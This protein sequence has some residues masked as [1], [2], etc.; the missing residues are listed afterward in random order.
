MTSVEVQ[1]DIRNA[2][3]ASETT[4]W[5]L[6]RLPPF[7]AVAMRLIQMYANPDIDI[8]EVGRTIAMEPVFAARVLRLANSPLFAARSEVKSLSHA[9]VLLGLNRVKAITITRAMA[10]Y[11]TPVLRVEALRACW[12]NN[13]AAAIVSE[14]LARACKMDPDFAYVAGLI[15][16]IG[17]LALVV[18]YPQAYANLL[19]VTEENSFNLLTVEHDL[20]ELDHCQAGTWLLE[21][22]S[23]PAELRE[24]VAWHHEALG[25][26]PFRMVNLVHVADLM[27]DTLGF[28]VVEHSERRSF[29]SLLELLPEGARARF[30]DD[31]E[32]LA[33]E[34]GERILSWQ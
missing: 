26:N 3:G 13:L 14:K 22:S 7:P 20:F 28:P 16:D 29:E 11:V 6:D 25:A 34:I 31:A 24:V 23:F 32:A 10:D 17:R 2:K 5:A 15:R 9:I 30:P 8:T 21:Q 4:P 12:R 27:T 19:A 18:K 1:P 33:V